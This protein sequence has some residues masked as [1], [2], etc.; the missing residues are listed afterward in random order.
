MKDASPIPHPPPV[1]PIHTHEI[2]SNGERVQPFGARQPYPGPANRT[3]S[4]RSSVGTS[5]CPQCRRRGLL[6]LLDAVEAERR[7]RAHL[8]FDRLRPAPPLRIQVRRRLWMHSGDRVRRSKPRWVPGQRYDQC[9]A[10]RSVHPGPH[11][12]FPTLGLVA[13]AAARSPRVGAI[14]SSPETDPVSAA[15]G[16]DRLLSVGRAS[17][18]ARASNALGEG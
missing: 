17:G 4:H 2:P 14:C 5:L 18:V 10:G 16:V 7:I 1:R 8:R 13:R 6:T 3:W 12:C 11:H 9:Q 15:G